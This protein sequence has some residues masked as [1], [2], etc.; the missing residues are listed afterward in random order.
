M[1]LLR[2]SWLGRRRSTFVLFTGTHDAAAARLR[3]AGVQH[4]GPQP[5]AG[6]RILQLS[7]PDGNRVV[8]TGA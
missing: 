5:G 3:G 1:A 7:D 6:A 4:E 2:S 8:I